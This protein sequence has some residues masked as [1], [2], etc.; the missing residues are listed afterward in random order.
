MMEAMRRGARGWVGKILFFF[1]IVS[2]GIWGI[3][4]VFTG[5]NRTTLAK[6]GAT[7]VTA[8]EF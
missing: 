7:T 2:F 3:A 6:V 8:N 4:D 1:L 5:F